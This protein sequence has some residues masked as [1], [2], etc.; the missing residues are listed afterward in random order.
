MSSRS[1]S[2][3][4][5]RRSASQEGRDS[6]FS[7]AAGT[8]DVRKRRTALAGVEFG[9]HRRS[10]PR[11]VWTLFLKLTFSRFSASGIS[12]PGSPPRN[13]KQPDKTV[14]GWASR[15]SKKNDV[16]VAIREFFPVHAYPCPV[17]ARVDEG[18]VGTHRT[19]EIPKDAH[20]S[21][22]A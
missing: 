6:S 13:R 21:A 22:L 18:W 9:R 1:L 14:F 11:G 7:T 16:D 20:F 4:Q 10:I 19:A 15:S 3:K 17:T 2:T 8:T 12:I 5:S